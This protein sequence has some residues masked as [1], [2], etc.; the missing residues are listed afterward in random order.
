VDF[1]IDVAAGQ[2]VGDGFG[3]AAQSFAGFRA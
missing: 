2:A 1:R 3:Q